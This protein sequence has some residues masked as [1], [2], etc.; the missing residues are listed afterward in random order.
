MNRKLILMFYW[1]TTLLIGLP[2]ITSPVM[3]GDLVVVVNLDNPNPRLSHD[4]VS[5]LYLGRTRTF[6]NGMY[7]YVIDRERDS[8]MRNRF[9]RLI[10]GMHLNQVNT[11]WARLTFSGQ[12]LPPVKKNNN[13]EVLQSVQGN[14]SG[15]GYIDGDAL[16]P[17]VR[18]VLRLHD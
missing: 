8:Q 10:N 11:Y 14:P 4:Q 13:L 7:A 6:P 3:A 15:I 2:A 16:V 5:D 9:F 18:E 1:I 17:S 12:V